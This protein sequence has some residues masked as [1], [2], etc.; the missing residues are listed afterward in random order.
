MISSSP[1]YISQRIADAQEKVE[2]YNFDVRKHL[3]EYDDVMNQHRKVIY[4]YRRNILDG[5]EQMHDLV[6]DMIIQ[7]VQDV[8]GQF[9]NTKKINT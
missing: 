3:L 5:E 8:F 1:P 7:G 4:Q 6:R 9:C 2:K